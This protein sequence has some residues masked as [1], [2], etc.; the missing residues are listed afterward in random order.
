MKIFI[1]LF[2]LFPPEASH[3]IA[4]NSLKI[5]HKFKLLNLFFPKFKA[6]AVQLFGLNFSNRLGTAAGLDK[7]GDFIDCLGALGF[8]FIE[9]G[10]V[11]PLPQPGNS[12]PRV[13]RLPNEQAVIN[14]LGFNNKGV[15]YLVRNLKKRKY[16]GIIGVN[17]GANKKSKDKERINDYIK[18]F[19]KV[20][21][22]SDY[23]TVNISS[24]NTPSLRDLHD[25]KNV[26]ILINELENQSKVL[27]F[28]GPIF[29]KISPDEGLEKILNIASL[30]EKSFLTG[31]IISNTTTNKNM[32]DDE[33][34]H[35]YEGGLSGKPLMSIS[36]SC[37]KDVK[38]RYPDLPLIGVGGVFDKND[39]TKK[40]ECGAS[41]VQIY[42]GF[43]VIGP[44]IVYNILA[45]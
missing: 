35:S 8:G 13:F 6:K 44:K 38:D 18:C 19:T 34:Y 17:I 23:I 22:Y 16:E 36:T 14:R 27:N 31:L 26:R 30:V 28:S 24:P 1:S 25:D 3:F 7:N 2:K 15:D 41:L 10:T 20:A 29:L 11:T 5:L 21:N 4:L 40:I 45:E 42:T 9:V 33:K 39:F 37:L 12:K 43:I 32:L